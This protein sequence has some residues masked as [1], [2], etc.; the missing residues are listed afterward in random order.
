MAVYV[1]T[2]AWIALHER[3]D[4]H[5]GA[6]KQTLQGLLASHEILVTGVHTL[7]EFADGLARHYDQAHAADAIQ[8]L[9]ESSALR[10]DPSEPHWTEA[11]KVF[12]ARR[13]W[14]VDLTDCLS[15]A[16]MDAAGIRRAFTFDRDFDK[17][18]LER[19]PDVG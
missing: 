17:A 1:D 5:H 19:V 11:L 16:L 14:N 13:D 18:G 3:R 7:V 6:A 8:R 15:F 12:T 2:S 10:I 9:V 4:R